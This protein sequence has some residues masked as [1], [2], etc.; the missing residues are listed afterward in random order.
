MTVM[1]PVIYYLLTCGK[2]RVTLQQV[3]EGAERPRR[4]VME[5]IRKLQREGYIEVTKEEKEPAHGSVHGR[6]RRCPTLKIIGDLSERPKAAPRRNT[7]RDK[8][9]KL[10]RAKR[11]FTSRE[12]EVASG[13]SNASVRSYITLLKKGGYIRKTGKDGHYNTFMLIKD[14]V[15]RPMDVD[16]GRS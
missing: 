8:I 14:Q 13:A 2:K 15:Q 10:I 11:Y 4:P 5:A 6:P 12:I 1:D 16:K 9:W 7:M 3:M